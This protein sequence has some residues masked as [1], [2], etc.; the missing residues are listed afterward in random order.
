M[1]Q[2]LQRAAAEALLDCH[3]D[4]DHHRSVLTLGHPSR[5]VVE[6]AARAVARVA[7]E[8]IDL[9]A[10]RGVHPRFGA[11]DVVPFVPLSSTGSPLAPDAG[12]AALAAGLEHA[13]QAR[14]RFVRWAA[15]E[16][17]LPCFVYGPERSLPEVRRTAFSELGPDEGPARPHPSAGACAVGARHALVAYNLW[18]AGCTLAVAR[19]V[20][21][22]IRSPQVRALGL[23]VGAGPQVSCNLVDPMRLGPA[24][25]YDLVERLVRAAG[26]TVARAELVGLVPLAVVLATPPERW[27][28]LD[29]DPQRTVEARMG[30]LP[31]GAIRRLPEE[32]RRRLPDG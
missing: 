32:V 25:V 23:E 5:A 26:G 12:P 15:T 29:L 6:A 4:A 19:Q 8:E 28:E 21:K 10:H 9:R 1:L 2:H 18:L 7:V 13:L 20:A 27:E 31:A 30:S 3:H 24:P 11:I 14:Q 17:Q 22:R 16:L